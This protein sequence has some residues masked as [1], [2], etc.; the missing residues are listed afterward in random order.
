MLLAFAV[1]YMLVVGLVDATLKGILLGALYL[2]AT[3]GEVPS[4]FDRSVMTGSFTPKA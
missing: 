4:E 3:A 1:I 2:Y